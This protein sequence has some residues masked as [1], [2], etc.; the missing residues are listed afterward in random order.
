MSDPLKSRSLGVSDEA[1]ADDLA[2][3][4][5]QP[6][7]PSRAGDLGD[8]R[9]RLVENWIVAVVTVLS[10]GVIVAT[11]WS[12]RDQAKSSGQS[13]REASNPGSLAR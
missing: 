3:A 1:V 4:N 2:V 9:I 13:A 6:E 12:Q 7:P 10:A 5:V 11:L 8:D